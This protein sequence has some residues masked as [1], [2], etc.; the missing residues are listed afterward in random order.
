MSRLAIHLY[1]CAGFQNCVQMDTVESDA[2]YCR[3]KV[4]VGGIN[5]NGN[6][7]K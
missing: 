4:K 1:G 5:N 3:P 2:D 6:I 7:P